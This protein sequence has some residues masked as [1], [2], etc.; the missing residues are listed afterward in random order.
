MKAFLVIDA[1]V[2]IGLC[3][4]VYLDTIRRERRVTK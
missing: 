1:I 2:L 4:Y 3:A